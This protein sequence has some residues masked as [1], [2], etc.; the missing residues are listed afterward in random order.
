MDHEKLV[1]AVRDVGFPIVV[2]LVL[3]WSFV[4]R[5]PADLAQLTAAIDRNTAALSSIQRAQENAAR[6]QEAILSAVRR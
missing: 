1:R 6:M 5:L 4:V 3:L 2:A